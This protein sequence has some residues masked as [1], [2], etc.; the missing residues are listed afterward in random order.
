M[1]FGEVLRAQGYR[2][3]FAYIPFRKVDRVR[4]GRSSKGSCCIIVVCCCWA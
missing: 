3:Q 1:H 4:V 2:S